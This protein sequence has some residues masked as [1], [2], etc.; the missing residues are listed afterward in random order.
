MRLRWYFASLLFPLLAFTVS[1]ADSKNIKWN[2]TRTSAPDSVVE[3]K[4]LQETVKD[5]VA[6]V[7]PATVAV[8]LGEIDPTRSGPQSVGAGSGVI[9]SDDGL[10][11]TAAHV[12]EPPSFGFGAFTPR[13]ER[14]PT[15]V[16][17]ILPGNIEVNAKILGRNPG[18]DSGMVKITDTVPEKAMWPGAKEGKWPFVEI[19]DSAKLNKG[20]WVVSLGHP[21]GP[22]RERRAP[23]RLGQM[24]NV[25]NA[26]SIVSD[27][28]LVGG[29]SG[30]PLFDLTGK[31]VGIH[32]RI[33]DKLEDNV[34]VSTKAFQDDWR[35]LVRGDIIGRGESRA[36]LGVTLNRKGNLEPIVDEFSENSPSEKAGIKIGDR[37]LKI[38]DLP[39]VKTTDVDEIMSQFRPGDIIAVQF[40]RGDETLEAKVTLGRRNNRPRLPE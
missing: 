17:L 27:C 35:R 39:I 10:V 36:V 1:A 30:G 4:A 2:P 6:K 11:L 15:M 31:L 26:K 13:R 22:K 5:L 23:V 25:E 8:I 9:V 29:D 32:S 37:L 7:T 28:T 34:H 14:G 12:I 16:R 18:L 19:G 33:G 24:V 38:N 3:L 21:G 20:Q 40:Q